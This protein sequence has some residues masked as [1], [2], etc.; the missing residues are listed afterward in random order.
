MA[1]Y[2]LQDFDPNYHDTFQGDDIKIYCIYQKFSF[3]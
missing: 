1:L 3:Q 2:K